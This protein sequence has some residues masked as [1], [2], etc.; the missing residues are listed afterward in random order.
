MTME[1]RSGITADESEGG[2][3]SPWRMASP[4]HVGR[5]YLASAPVCDRY[6]YVVGGCLS[7]GCSTGEVYDVETGKWAP[8]ANTLV[9]RDSLG[10]KALIKMFYTFCMY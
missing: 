5:S 4:M 10:K 8:I 7:D 1:E 6:V 3:E 2:I 9:K